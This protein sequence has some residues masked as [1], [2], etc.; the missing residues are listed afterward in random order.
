MR[1]F[2]LCV[3]VITSFAQIMIP[4]KYQQKEF[5]RTIGIGYGMRWFFNDISGFQPVVLPDTDAPRIDSRPRLHGLMLYGRLEPTITMGMVAWGNL[6]ESDNDFGRAEWLG[7]M[8]GIFVEGRKDKVI[9]NWY[10][11]AGFSLYYGYFVL[12]A[13]SEET[14]YTPSIRTGTMILEPSVGLGYDFSGIME[15]RI[16]GAYITSKFSDTQTNSAL[17]YDG[18][19]P[20]ENCWTISTSMRYN[21]PTM[22]E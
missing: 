17:E 2:L 14:D 19:K 22:I 15:L 5:K 3:L 13:S 9:M 1:I 21:I 8:A 10:G 6:L 18:P 4:N 20:F 11:T 12:S 16:T 7:M